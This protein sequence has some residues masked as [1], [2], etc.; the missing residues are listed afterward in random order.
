MPHAADKIGNYQPPHLLVPDMNLV[1]H[2]LLI[3]RTLSLEQGPL[4]KQQRL[5]QLCA[6]INALNLENKDFIF[7]G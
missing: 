7:I 4:M 1:V 6:Y 5:D 2:I 3:R